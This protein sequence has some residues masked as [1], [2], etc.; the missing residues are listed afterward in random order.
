MS[1]VSLGFIPNTILVPLDQ[2]LPSRKTPAGLLSSKKYRQIVASIGEVGLIEPLSVMPADTESGQYLL[3]DGHIRLIAMRELGH[4][5]ASCLVAKDDEN[6]T[7][8]TRVNRVSTIQ[9]HFMIRRAIDRG[10]SP[11]KLAKTLGVDVSLIHKKATLLVGIC[12][13]AADMLNDRHFSTNVSRVLKQMKPLRQVEC[14]ELMI[15]A[16]N[17]SSPYADALLVATP[18]NMLIDGK[19]PQKQAG[20]TPEQMSR[21]EREMSK[22]QGQYKM[23]EQTYGEDVLNLVLARGYLDKLLSNKAVAR[24]IKQR[25]PEVLEQFESIIAATSLEH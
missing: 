19:K 5:Q 21:M 1:K 20:V 13:E 2:L 22:V 18:A 11:D 6:Y 23:M 7:Y 9:E 8:N 4:G 12:A 3:L 10:V 16:N 25:Q 24:Y 15:S 14:V 17:L